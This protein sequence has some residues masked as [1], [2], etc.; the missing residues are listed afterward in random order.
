MISTFNPA[1]LFSL[2]LFSCFAVMMFFI[3]LKTF[4]NTHQSLTVIVRFN[5]FI[6]LFSALVF[7]GIVREH[8]MPLVPILFASTMLLTIVFALS[9]AGA[10]M[11]NQLSFTALLGFQAFRLPLELI[12]HHWAKLKTIPE[13]MTWTGQ[14][15]DLITGIIALVALPALKRSLP[16]VWFVQITGFVLLLNV[17]RVALL[18]SPLPFA[19]S[20]DIPL[21]LILYFP[22]ALIVPL[23][24]AP[25][26]FCH[27]LVFRKLRG[28]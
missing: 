8:I 19:W 14:N 5:F 3:I 26:L 20:L 23:F 6:I 9:Q 28:K 18:S 24:V 21:Q 1:D 7:F 2:S 25:A 16:L 13:T 17:I 4:R 11:A 22:Y 15:Y 10:K 27:L 12:L